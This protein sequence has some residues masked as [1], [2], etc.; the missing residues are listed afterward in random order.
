MQPQL[1][2]W[3]KGSGGRTEAE[4]LRQAGVSDNETSRKRNKGKGTASHYSVDDILDKPTRRYPNL[5]RLSGRPRQ[6]LPFSPSLP[7][8]PTPQA[9]AASPDSTAPASLPVVPSNFPPRPL[10]PPSSPR[11][12]LPPQPLGHDVLAGFFSSDLTIPP[13]NIRL[14]TNWPGYRVEKLYLGA[15]DERGY[16]VFSIER[17]ANIQQGLLDLDRR[18]DREVQISGFAFKDSLP[19]KITCKANSVGGLYA[20]RAADEGGYGD[21]NDRLYLVVETRWTPEFSGHV[22]NQPRSPEGGLVL[23]DSDI[24]LTAFDKPHRNLAPFVSRHFLLTLVLP[25]DRSRPGHP[26]TPRSLAALRGTIDAAEHLP[27]LTCLP[28]LSL[29]WVKNYLPKLAMRPLS[30]SLRT[31]S[32]A[33]AYH[34]EG[35]LRDGTA[36]PLELIDLIDKHILP[37]VSTATVPY[38]EALAEDIVIELRTRLDEDRKERKRLLKLGRVTVEELQKAPEHRWDLP[39]FAEESRQTVILQRDRIEADLKVRRAR[40]EAGEKVGELKTGGPDSR[41]EHFWC[42][43]IVYTPSGTIKVTGR[44]LEKVRLVSVLPFSPSLTACPLLEQRSHPS[45]LSPRRRPR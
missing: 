2:G 38:G 5:D 16:G 32:P 23:P 29:V 7:P 30:A 27:S 14:S 28:S 25:P 31:V 6:S 45:L 26:P 37:W 35:I 13:S 42:R 10:R 43:S 44:R 8:R 20:A 1:S 21:G 39:T 11:Y 18:G 19:C 17:D 24:R 41:G 15:F 9:P 3:A 36:F 12:A 34:L 4:L 22:S 33:I 40:L